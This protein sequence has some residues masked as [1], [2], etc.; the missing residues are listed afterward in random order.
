MNLR[1]TIYVKPIGESDNPFT[2]HEISMTAYDIGNDEVWTLKNANSYTTYTI[3]PTICTT[4]EL[5][6]TITNQKQ[7]LIDYANT[8]GR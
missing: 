6:E 8:N 2:T 5:A 3:E 4:E 1:F 7:K